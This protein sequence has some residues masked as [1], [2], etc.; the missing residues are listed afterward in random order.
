MIQRLDGGL[1]AGMGY[2]LKKGTGM[3][4]GIKY[5]YGLGDVYKEKTGTK[6]RYLL[7]KFNLPIGA[8]KES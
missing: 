3:T 6:N 1:M 2:I 8:K 4:L 7:L 5:Y